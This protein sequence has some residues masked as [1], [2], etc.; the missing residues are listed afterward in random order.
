MHPSGKRS[1]I[2]QSTIHSMVS[3]HRG[4]KKLETQSCGK[5]H[6]MVR[7]KGRHTAKLKEAREGNTS[8]FR[9]GKQRSVILTRSCVQKKMLTV[10]KQTNFL[11]HPFYT[12]PISNSIAM[13]AKKKAL[14]DRKVGSAT[15]NVGKIWPLCKKLIN[16]CSFWGLNQQPSG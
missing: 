9:K 7:E 8:E 2:C 11:D 13:G 4:A 10:Q 14:F 16:D 3:T 5:L 6:E 1:C 15:K 12:E